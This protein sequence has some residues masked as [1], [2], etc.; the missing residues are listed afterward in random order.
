MNCEKGVFSRLSHFRARVPLRV[1]R[2]SGKTIERDMAKE[3]QFEDPTDPLVAQILAQKD[4]GSYEPPPDYADLKEMIASRQ[5][6]LER[7]QSV[8]GVSLQKNW[9]DCRRRSFR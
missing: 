2:T 9:R 1:R 7:K 6:S 8:C 3:L 4:S 5:R